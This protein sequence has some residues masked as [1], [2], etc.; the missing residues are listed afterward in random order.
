MVF[1]A[2]LGALNPRR[3]LLVKVKFN[4]YGCPSQPTLASCSAPAAHGHPG[5]ISPIPRRQSWGL[6]QGGLGLAV[7]STHNIP[8]LFFHL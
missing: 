8:Q 6:G 3:W 4:T 5:F 1:S 7:S 2:G